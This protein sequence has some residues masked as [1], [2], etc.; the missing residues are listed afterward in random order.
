V[1]ESSEQSYCLY[2]LVSSDSPIVNMCLN[3][4]N[5]PIVN[6]CLNLVNSPIVNMC[7]NLGNSPI[8]ESSEQSYC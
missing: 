1:F 2:V 8:V 3:L 5:S 4:V 6:M 7:L